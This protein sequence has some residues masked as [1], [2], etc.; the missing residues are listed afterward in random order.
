MKMTRETVTPE[1]LDAMT[2]D[3]LWAWSAL[4]GNGVRPVAAARDLFP[5][6]PA[7]YVGAARDLKN[8]AINKAVA[9]KE[10]AEGRIT[11][12]LVYEAICDRIYEG[13]PDYARVW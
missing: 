4:V 11:T 5:N 6:R 7:G 1:N 13:L 2:P 9:M 12:A 8:Y 10:R 3:A